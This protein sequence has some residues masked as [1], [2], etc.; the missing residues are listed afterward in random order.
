MCLVYIDG[1]LFFDLD[2]TNFDDMLSKLRPASL[3]LQ[4]E[5]DFT[6]VLDVKLNV[7]KDHSKVELT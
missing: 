7:D 1:Y 2:D 3:T 5:N 6:G 4:R